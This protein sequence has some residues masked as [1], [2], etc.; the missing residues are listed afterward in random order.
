MSQPK[1][2]EIFF[3]SD[4]NGSCAALD[5]LFTSRPEFKVR[6]WFDGKIILEYLDAPDYDPNYDPFKEKK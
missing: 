1:I 4:D 2:L 5:A 6:A 3:T